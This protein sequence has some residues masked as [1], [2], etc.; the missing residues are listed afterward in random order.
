MPGHI[1]FER[2]KIILCRIDRVSEEECSKDDQLFEIK[3]GNS[4]QVVG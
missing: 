3:I 1:A 2:L 4:V